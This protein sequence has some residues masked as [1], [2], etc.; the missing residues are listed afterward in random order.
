M[1][2]LSASKVFV[3]DK[4]PAVES[5]GLRVERNTLLLWMID[6][7]DVVVAELILSPEEGWELAKDIV[8]IADRVAGVR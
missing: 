1:K 3:P 5:V 6:R 2:R 8:A 7:D 4:L